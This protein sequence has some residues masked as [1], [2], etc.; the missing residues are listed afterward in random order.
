MARYFVLSVALAA[1]AA[2]LRADGFEGQAAP[3][4]ARYCAACHLPPNVQ[5]GLD[6]ARF[7]TD[8]DVR[9]AR[10]DWHWLRER[11]AAREMPPRGEPQ[12]S[13]AEREAFLAWLGPLVADDGAA[14]A[15]PSAGE[16]SPGRPVL[17]RLTRRAYE[18]AVRD[19]CGVRFDASALLP[20]DPVGFGFEGVGEAQTLSEAEVEAFL[21][22]ALDVAARALPYDPPG[23]AATVRRVS[24]E[25]FDGPGGRRGTVW[26]LHVN[27]SVGADVALP[28]AGRY[29]VRAG[30]HGDQAGDAPVRVRLRLGEAESEPIDVPEGEGDPT[31]TIEAELSAELLPSAPAARAAVRFVNDYWDPDFPDPARRD[32][33]LAVHWIEV[34]G[35]LDPLPRT[36][37]AAELEEVTEGLRG[38]GRLRAA[39]AHLVRRVWRRPAAQREL[40]RLV[41]LGPEKAAYPLRLQHALAA[42]L[43]SPNFVFLVEDSEAAAEPRALTGP[44]LAARLAFTLWASVPDR[45]LDALAD[46]GRLAEPAVLLAAIDRMLADPRAEALVDTFV[47]PW[48]HLTPLAGW[49]VDEARFPEF[50]PELRRSMLGETR[51]LV[52]AHLREERPLS[53]LL[54]GSSSFVD[55]RLAAHYGV[56]FDPARGRWQEVDLAAVGRRGLLGHASVLTITSEPTRTSPVKRGKWVL[57]VLLGSPPPPPPPGVDSLESGRGADP[58]LSLRERLALHRSDPNCAACHTRMDPLGFGLEEYDAIGRRREVPRAE[59]AATLPDGR[60]FAGADELVALLAAEGLFARQVTERLA[61]YALGRPLTRAD[62]PHVDAAL[63]AAG[64]EPSLRGILRGVLTSRAFG[65]VAGPESAGA[66]NVE[67]SPEAGAGR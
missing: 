55:A 47:L 36:A 59:L 64:P 63:A 40:D 57:E 26:H 24:T 15:Q 29:R 21:D 3:F 1:C 12:P 58:T 44:E 50:T 46:A 5:G 28:R 30:V 6:L 35:P 52:L 37:L 20:P 33:N 22:A 13:D 2:P 43:A 18:N 51:R 66:V 38:N 42:L 49:T 8:A 31:R 11:V 67:A 39:L 4:L 10:E 34:E 53:G 60:T 54:A 9:G 62:R 16:A 41:R 65:W 45:E 27:G 19:L 17:R 48:L 56:P 32:R 61:V 14:A 25:R 23:A 7:T